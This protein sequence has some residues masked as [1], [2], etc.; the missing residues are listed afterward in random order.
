MFK[1]GKK[2]IL[3]ELG[4]IKEQLKFLVSEQQKNNA[5][6]ISLG[7]LER[8]L[9]RRELVIE[10]Q[11]EKIMSRDYREYKTYASSE[12]ANLPRFPTSVDLEAFAGE[13]V[14]QQMLE[15]EDS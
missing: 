13:A 1:R 4:E 7:I 14:T 9:E 3:E 2:K 5:Q 12:E 6:I 11:N 10:K 15:G 8:L